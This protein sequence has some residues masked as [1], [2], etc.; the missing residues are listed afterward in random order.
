MSTTFFTAAAAAAAASLTLT[1]CGGGD[2]HAPPPVTDCGAG[3]A[4][5]Y[6]H[7]VPP[8]A[9]FDGKTYAQWAGGFWKWAL[10]LP[11]EGHPFTTC[12]RDFSIRQSGPVWYWSAPDTCP[13]PIAA[14]IPEGKA[15]LLTIRDVE[16]SSLEPPPFHGD[17][18]AQQ[19]ANSKYWADHIVNVFATIDGKPVSNLK[20][21]RFSTPQIRFTAPTPWIF[22]STGGAGTSVGD[23]YYLL[24]DRLSKG[25]HTI[26]YGGT[27]HFNAGE[28]GPDP[29]DLVKDISIDLTVTKEQHVCS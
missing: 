1:A 2:N 3:T 18:E 27:F 5:P 8:D 25:K 21:H 11:L 19:R 24:L 12:V 13:A 17:T 22:G 10:E 6:V 29:V 14:S 20:A 26:H 15:L 28:L 7:I 9:K 23:G 4:A 16:T